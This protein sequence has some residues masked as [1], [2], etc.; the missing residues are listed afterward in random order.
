[1]LKKAGQWGVKGEVYIT[2][3]ADLGAVVVSAD[4]PFSQGLVKYTSGV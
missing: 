3:P 2:T 1:M 4:P